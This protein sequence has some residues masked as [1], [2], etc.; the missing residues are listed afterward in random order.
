M[1]TS[2]RALSVD[3][4]DD[5]MRVRLEDGGTVGAP[6]AW[7]PRRLHGAAEARRQ[8]EISPSGLHWDALDGDISIVGLLAG[9]GDMTSSRSR[10]A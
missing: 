2:A 6:T 10:A 8:G 4:S 3:C 5:Q 9:R 7:F 1:T